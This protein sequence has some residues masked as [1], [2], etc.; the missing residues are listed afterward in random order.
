MTEYAE[1]MG[2][3][4]TTV[5]NWMDKWKTFKDA[6]EDEKRVTG[7]VAESVVK[8]NIELAKKEQA[9]KDVRVDASD[10][11]WYLSR[12]RRGKFALRQEHTGADGDRLDIHVTID[13]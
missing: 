3:D 11:K 9:E 7:D 4:R 5:Y 10:A 12:V 8:K 13:D 6:W 2:V 1:K